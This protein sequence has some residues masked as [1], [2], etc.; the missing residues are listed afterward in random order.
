M[1]NGVKSQRT[2]KRK[3]GRIL[4]FE[5]GTERNTTLSFS[6]SEGIF[7]PFIYYNK[8]SYKRSAN[9]FDVIRLINSSRV[10]YIIMY[11]FYF[12]PWIVVGNV[13]YIKKRLW[14][15]E[16]PYVL[17]SGLTDIANPPLTS[18]D[19]KVFVASCF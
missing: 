19:P 13:K 1:G 2:V 18:V 8:V 4:L 6:N 17:K 7:H 12:C 15:K 9:H 5:K 11:P 16:G 10:L 3:D 14:V